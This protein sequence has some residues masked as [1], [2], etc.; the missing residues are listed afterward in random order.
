MIQYRFLPERKT[1]GRLLSLVGL[2]LLIGGLVLFLTDKPAAEDNLPLLS[3]LPV[4]LAFAAVSIYWRF[5]GYKGDQ[6]LLP[7]VAF[8]SANG[9]IFL[10]RLDP[11]YALRQAAWLAIALVCLVLITGYCRNYLFLSDYQYIYVLAGVVLLILPIFFGIEQGGAKSWLNF[12]LF[13]VQSSEFVKILLV[14]FLTGYLTENRPVLAVGNMN[15]GFISIPE[16]KYWVPLIAM[17]AVSLLLL[18]FQ[19]DL[20]TA[21]IYFGTFLAM[22]YIATARL[23]YIFSGMALFLLGAGFSYQF[24]S[25]VR[26][27]VLVWLNPWPYSDTSGYQVIQSI[28]ALAS[29]GITGNGFNAGF[30][31]FIPAVHTDFIFSAI[32]EEMGFLGGAGIIL[33]YLLMVYRG[34]RITLSSRDDFSMLLAAGLTV[35]ISFQ[36]FIIIAGVTKLLPLTGVTL[37]FV[38]YGGSSLVANFVLLGLLLNVSNEAEQL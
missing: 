14:L 10:L 4:M 11:A 35:L 17:W 16:A 20:G 29:G 37:P 34:L 27:R 9:L 21:L 6:L 5:T 38:S 19:K 8:L 1:E 30:P 15:L 31:K 36:A 13:Q 33:I 24:F 32:G 7:M 22:L 12:G 18:V 3:I 23:S 28:V 25:H 2:Y 26:T